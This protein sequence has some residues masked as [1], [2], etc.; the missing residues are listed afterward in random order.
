MTNTALSFN[1]DHAL[2]VLGLFLMVVVARLA[3][4]AYAATHTAA[5]RIRGYVARRAIDGVAFVGW[6]ADRL[7]R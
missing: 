1:G 3:D 6:L 7:P 5:E 2:G 4:P